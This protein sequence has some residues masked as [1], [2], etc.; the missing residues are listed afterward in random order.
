MSASGFSMFQRQRLA[1]ETKALPDEKEDEEEEPI[2]PKAE[3]PVLGPLWSRGRW[4]VVPIQNQIPNGPNVNAGGTSDRIKS[5][6]RRRRLA[7]LRAI[8]GPFCTKKA[9]FSH[10]D[11]DNHL[12]KIT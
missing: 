5:K 9:L 10:V 2:D 6:G 11:E 4:I 7:R 3:C 8:Q 1:G 12:W